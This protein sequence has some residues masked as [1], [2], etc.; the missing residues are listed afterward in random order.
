MVG[1]KSYLCYDFP[2]CKPG[3]PV[4]VCT[5]DGAH[6]PVSVDDGITTA[7]DCLKA[8]VPPGL[9]FHLPVVSAEVR[10]PVGARR[11]AVNASNAGGLQARSGGARTAQ[12]FR[13]ISAVR[14]FRAST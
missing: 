10:W 9:G 3:Y 12:C 8:F 1:S 11:R 14:P 2:G 5:F 13:A 7:D 4:K 6:T